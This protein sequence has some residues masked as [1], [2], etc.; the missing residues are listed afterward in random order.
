MPCIVLLISLVVLFKGIY[1]S[2]DNYF[3]GNFNGGGTIVHGGQ[4]S[5]G[6]SIQGGVFRGYLSRGQFSS[7]AIILELSHRLKVNF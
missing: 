5:S 6:A 1:V 2:G 3:C 7:G 4:F